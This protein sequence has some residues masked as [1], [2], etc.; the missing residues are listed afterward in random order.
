[1]LETR[2]KSRWSVERCA[3]SVDVYNEDSAR[4]VSAKC[5]QY[6]SIRQELSSAQLLP[7]RRQSYAATARTQ[8]AAAR[9]FSATCL[10]I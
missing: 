2:C 4:I 8:R 6:K 10:F 1:M 3:M 9:T 5:A 7:A